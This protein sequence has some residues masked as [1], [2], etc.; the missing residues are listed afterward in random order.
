MALCTPVDILSDAAVY[1]S[2]NFLW[3]VRDREM[4]MKYSWFEIGVL[5]YGESLLVDFK[6]F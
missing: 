1:C 6:G 4:R 2:K 5:S 3:E